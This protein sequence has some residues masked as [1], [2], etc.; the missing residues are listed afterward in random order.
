MKKIV[1]FLLALTI[2][3]STVAGCHRIT[4]PETDNIPVSSTGTEKTKL[5]YELIPTED[6]NRNSEGAFLE[7]KDGRILFAY[8]RY[9]TGGFDD[10]AVADIYAI[11]SEDNGNT[12]GEPFPFWTHEQAQADNVMS[13]SLMRMNNGDLGMFYLAKRDGAQCLLYL[14]RSTDEGQTW[15]NPVLCSGEEGFYVGNNDRVIRT[16]TGRLVFPTALAEATCE[17]DEKGNKVVKSLTPG[18]LVVFGSDDDGLS[19]RA[20]NEPVSIPV[21]R[22]CTTGVQEPGILELSDGRLWCWIRT[23]AGRQYETFSTD[24]GETWSAPLPS[25][26][27]S[28][29]SPLC[30]K[31]LS[32]GNLLAIWNPVPVYN[33]VSQY[34]G[35]VWLAARNPLSYAI[36]RD[37]G[38][39]FSKPINIEDDPNRGFCYTAIHE[40]EDGI[41]LAYCA[42]GVEDGDCRNRLR[43]T[44]LYL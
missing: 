33:G 35:K 21:S 15:S 8:S 1:I 29:I 10:G 44:K 42:G 5:I 25:A 43:I 20:L 40:T 4:E 27:T 14:I 11:L 13:V 26:F 23:D 2:I 36:S 6:N 16:Q 18:Q 3:F 17:I 30:M 12:F 38:N 39:T 24:G 19:W 32:T 37:G 7:L 41:L 34:H 28:A 22:G 31:R 9:G